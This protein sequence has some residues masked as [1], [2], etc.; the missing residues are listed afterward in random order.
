MTITRETSARPRVLLL[1][2]L[3]LSGCAEPDQFLPSYIPGGPQGILGGTVTYSGPMPC[4]DQGHVVGAA[5][6]LAFDTRLLPPPAGLGTT[7]TS[8]AA[9]GGDVLFGGIVDR[10]TFKS[11]GSKWCPPASAPPVTVS[12]DWTVGPLPGAVYEVRGFYDYPGTFNPVFSITKLP[13]KGDIAGGAIDNV[14]EVLQFDADPR[15]RQIQLGTPDPTT[16]I[17]TIPPE[18][19]NI[20][21][22]AVTLALPLPTGLPIFYPSAVQYSTHACNGTTVVPAQAHDCA[23]PGP[24]DVNM[25][26]D[27]QLP[28]FSTGDLLGTEDS[29]IR[30]TATA[31]LPPSEAKKGSESPFNLP[32]YPNPDPI[33][34]SWQDVNGDGMLDIGDDHAAASDL[35]P[36][37]LPLSI[38]SK[39]TQS[40]PASPT[41]DLTAQASPAIILQGITIYQNLTNTLGWALNPPTT[42]P[43]SPLNSRPQPEV[44]VGITPAVICLNPTD[45][46]DDAMAVLVVSHPTDCGGNALLMNEG[47]TLSALR[48]QFGRTVTVA[49]NSMG[50]VGG[51]LP[52]GRYALNLVYGTGQAWSNPNEIGVCQALEPESSNGTMCVASVGSRSRLPSQ[53]HVLTIG[54]PSDPAYCV[55]HP[56][57]PCCTDA[58][59]CKCPGGKCP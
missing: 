57:P 33:V 56:V 27:Y 54:K 29:L 7:A 6:L 42:N 25:P 26:S 52:E 59:Q 2:A 36:S 14:A 49:Q 4:T 3:A 34:Y 21:G 51:C 12:A 58:S 18:G 45:F 48:K 8:L 32:V 10:L 35:L 17:Y 11:D 9:I 55:S 13:V 23:A 1:A 41:D 20:D 30:V 31:G 5:V 28:V 40:M 38:L 37:L 46:S 44:I 15:Y 16:G 39:L 53:D 50:E 43:S 19:S 24:C 22:I 47:D